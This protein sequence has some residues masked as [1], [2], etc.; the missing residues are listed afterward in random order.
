[1]IVIQLIVIF[2]AF[3]I[4]L[5]IIGGRHTHT[6][7]AWKKIALLFLIVAMVVAVIFPQITN[8]LAHLV[9]VGRGADLLLYLLTLAFITYSVNS[10][11]NRQQER[12]S[13]YRLA[14]KIALF[15][16]NNRYEIGVKK[17]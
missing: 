5:S 10:Y 9:G 4:L 2:V 13:L 11:L 17:R 14:R 8:D 7:K 3:G 6:G 16:A 12:D 15:D 1:L